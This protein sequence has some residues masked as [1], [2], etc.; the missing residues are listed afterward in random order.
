M[1]RAVAGSVVAPQLATVTPSHRV[2][3]FFVVFRD[4]AGACEATTHISQRIAPH[5]PVR[6]C[7]PGGQVAAGSGSVTWIGTRCSG[8]F[9]AEDAQR[10]TRSGN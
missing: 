2:I 5:R 9:R 6:K 8:V 3:D 1:L 10:A 4:L 7:W